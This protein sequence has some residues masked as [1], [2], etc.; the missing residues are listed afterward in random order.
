MRWY[1]GI[2]GKVRE[3]WQGRAITDDTRPE[4]Q[5]GGIAD[6]KSTLWQGQ[7]GIGVSDKV[8]Q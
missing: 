2:D 7:H 8:T 6:K 4:R 1:V 3:E 5:G